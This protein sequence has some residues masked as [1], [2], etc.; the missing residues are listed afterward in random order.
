M[1]G[2]LDFLL[3]LNIHTNLNEDVQ[4]YTVDSRYFEIEGTLLNIARY[5]YLDLS[6]L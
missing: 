4:A 5:P 2:F 1:T 3:V 6:D